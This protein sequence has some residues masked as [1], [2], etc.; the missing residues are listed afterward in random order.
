MLTQV[1]FLVGVLTLILPY[2]LI[3]L[4]ERYTHQH[5]LT[6][7][8]RLIMYQGISIAVRDYGQGDVVVL[9]HGFAGWS[10][11][12]E[13]LVTRFVAR[14]KRVIAVDMIGAGASARTN[15]SAHYTTDAQA[16]MVLAVLKQLGIERATI[17]GHSYGGRVAMQ[18]AILA[19][20]SVT[21]ILAIAPEAFA[22][23]RP[24]MAKL[25]VVPVIG[26]AL[27]FW[28]TAPRLIGIG[29]RSVSRRTE[30]VT[31]AQITRYTQPVYVQ[32]HLRAQICQSAAPKDGDMPVP[33]HLSRIT[34]PVFIIWGDRDP[35]FP[36]RDGLKLV[37]QLPQANLAI[38]PNC[39]HIPH[40][41]AADETWHLIDQAL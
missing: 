9:L 38:V 16:R 37:E 30:W 39:G 17:V 8:T 23:D 12:W 5:L 25:V 26:Y 34:C 22:T 29:L 6:P 20:A 11:T 18:M 28:S 41:E 14:Q 13:E 7:S 27:A 35:V 10:D 40:V 1:L 19:P 36:A 33:R 15:D 32:G 31:A 24:P 3:H 2:V 4:R 21:R